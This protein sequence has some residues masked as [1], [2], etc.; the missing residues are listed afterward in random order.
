M[1]IQFVMVEK[2]MKKVEGKVKKRTD[3]ASIHNTYKLQVV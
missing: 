3:V 2:K 1:K